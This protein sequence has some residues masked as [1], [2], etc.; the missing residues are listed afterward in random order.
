MEKDNGFSSLNK[1]VTAMPFGKK[2]DYWRSWCCKMNWSY[3]NTFTMR[4]NSA[5]W[6]LLKLPECW[7]L[8]RWS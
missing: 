6:N 4:A 1:T 7:Q 8:T 2:Q 5:K 3:G